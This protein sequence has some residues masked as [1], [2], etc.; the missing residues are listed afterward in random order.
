MRANLPEVSGPLA[1]GI[2]L[3]SGIITWGLFAEMVQRGQAV[4][5]D[6]ANLLKK[7]SFPRI[8]LPVIIGC[9]TLLNFSIAFCLFLGF[10]VVTGNFP[11]VIALAAIPLLLVQIVLGLS[12]G[13]I[14]GIWNV[15]VR[16]AGQ[17][18]GLVLQLWFWATPI[19]YPV[20]VL[21]DSIR[22]W[23]VWNPLYHLVDGYQK[24]FVNGQ[25][26]D[27]Q[28]VGLV[29]LLS[30]IVALYALSLFRRRAGDI[31]DQL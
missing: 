11:G 26:P 18:S 17:I 6:N 9:F 12:L 2:Y 15:F 25:P 7:L 24:V 3:C 5:L 27:W 20:S 16:D 14:L 30:A 10:L 28:A 31:V 1:Y 13:V 29:A 4:F 8:T 19:V 23:M 22:Q 21:P